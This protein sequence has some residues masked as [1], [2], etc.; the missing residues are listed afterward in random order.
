VQEAKDLRTTAPVGVAGSAPAKM[1]TGGV[2]ASARPVFVINMEG[3]YLDGALKLDPD[4][5]YAI[6]AF[7]YATSTPVGAC[8]VALYTR[9]RGENVLSPAINLPVSEVRIPKAAAARDLELIFARPVFDRNNAFFECNE[10]NEK[11]I[12]G[13]V[14]WKDEKDAPA[15]AAPSSAPPATSAA[16]APAP[17]STAAL[18]NNEGGSA[19]KTNVNLAAVRGGRFAKIRN[20]ADCNLAFG[21]RKACIA[22]VKVEYRE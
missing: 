15:A 21:D 9:L 10:A 16:P 19:I 12:V 22:P 18:H 2:S 7:D 14:T 4:T 13:V 20:F 11:F 8:P 1:G 17:T 5:E 6:F 3:R